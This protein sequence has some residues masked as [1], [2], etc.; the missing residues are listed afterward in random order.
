M[1]TTAAT[2]P[3]I[4]A[5]T[6]DWTR[7]S[8]AAWR[9]DPPRQLV[10][11]LRDYQRQSGRSGAVARLRRAACVLRHRFWSAVTSA[12]VP[13]DCTI[14]GGFMMP[15]PSGVVIHPAARIGPNCLLMQGVTIGLNRAPG[16]PTL[17][18]HVDVGPGAKIL[19]NITI[20][21]HAVI[22]A[23]AVVLRDVPDFA[24]MVGAPARR[25]R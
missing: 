19:G 18:G 23:N 5:D 12:D 13:L 16:A 21:V 8:V 1:T 14:D 3:E 7:E 25:I 24:V 17:R 22:G 9:W 4:S 20:G 10:R 11:A 15:H 6:P 2:A